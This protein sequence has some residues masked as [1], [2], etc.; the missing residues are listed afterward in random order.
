M[1]RTGSQEKI[2]KAKFF[3]QK[4]TKREPVRDWLKSLDPEDRRRIGT[5]IATCEYGWPVGAPTCAPL[6]NGL[7]EVRTNLTGKARIARVIFFMHDS[8]M[9]LL[10]GFIKKDQTT[11]KPDKDLALSRMKILLNSK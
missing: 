4:D 2:I 6:G 7:F 5:D 3:C 1:E 11:P 9:Y 10:H 8:T